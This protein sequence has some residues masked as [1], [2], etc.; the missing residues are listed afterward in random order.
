MLLSMRCGR[1]RASR[2]GALRRTSGKALVRL[3][4]GENLTGWP[5]GNEMDLGPAE[6][7]FKVK[8]LARTTD[9]IQSGR[10]RQARDDK[11]RRF[12][13]RLPPEADKR[14]DRS[15]PTRL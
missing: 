1:G 4:T 7:T 9:V 3:R 2:G 12:M 15:F 11:Q 8:I 10:P 6:A 5:G 14:D 13:D